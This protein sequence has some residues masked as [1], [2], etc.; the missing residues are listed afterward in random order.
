MAIPTVVRS[1]L[2]GDR[3]ELRM[4]D[5]RVL[6]IADT[7]GS[8]SRGA[9]V[10]LPAPGLEVR[11]AALAV[12][13]PVQAAV[14]RARLLCVRERPLLVRATAAPI[15]SSGSVAPGRLIERRTSGLHRV[16]TSAPRSSRLL[17]R[18]GAF[19]RLS[20][21]VCSALEPVVGEVNLSPIGWRQMADCG[22]V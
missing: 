10:H 1:I 5:G 16:A 19:K 20:A 17:R 3:G 7:K 13:M 9:V 8:Y 12:G 14:D 6:A 21:C 22:Y 11:L 2:A 18:M 15:V 4:A